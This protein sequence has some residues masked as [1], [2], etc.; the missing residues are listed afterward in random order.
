MNEDVWVEKR[1]VEFIKR[2]FDDLQRERE[3]PMAER[4]AAPRHL[5]L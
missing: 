3:P 4:V 5:V 1:T 2:T